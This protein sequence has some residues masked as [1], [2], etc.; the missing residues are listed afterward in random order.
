MDITYRDQNAAEKTAD[1]DDYKL[2]R[3]PLL[4]ILDQLAEKAV[5][6]EFLPKVPAGESPPSGSR[7][8]SPPG[9]AAPSA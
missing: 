8:A 6:A 3:E 7:P 9:A 1:F 4:L 5:N 2:E